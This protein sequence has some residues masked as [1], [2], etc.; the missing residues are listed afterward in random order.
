MC[1]LGEN[2]VYDAFIA[3]EVGA[4]ITQTGVN[5]PRQGKHVIQR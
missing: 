5:P 2:R 4:T 3:V 1:N